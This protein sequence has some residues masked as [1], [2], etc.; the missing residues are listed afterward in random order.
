MAYAPYEALWIVKESAFG[1]QK[2]SPV[3]GTDSIYIRLDGA[4]RFTMRANPIKKEIA[5]G[6]GFAAK[7]YSVSDKI[8]VKGKLDLEFCYSQATML[9][10]WAYTRINSG[11]TSPWTTTEIAGDMASCAIY[12]AI[13]RDDGTVKRTRY[14]GVKVN[15]ATLKSGVGDTTTMLSL[16]LIGQKMD[17]NSYDASSD[18]DGT[19]FPLPADT[20]FPTDPLLFSHL[21]A[22]VGGSGVSYLEG[23]TLDVTGQHD[24]RYFGGHFISRNH[25]RGRMATVSMELLYTA[26]PNWRSQM[27]ALTSQAATFAFTNGVNTV[28]INYQSNNLT[29]TVQ[30]DLSPGKEYNQ[31]VTL[32]NQWYTTGSADLTFTYA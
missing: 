7:G 11:Q 19:A 13:L 1:T 4:N 14:K 25:L 17:A 15:K 12:H 22:T 6:G 23:L 10:G 3:A 24:P 8:E 26:S 30:D 5:F 27:E 28:T 2:T 32:T 31:T 16:D 29:E 9:G 21:T 18:P 20:A